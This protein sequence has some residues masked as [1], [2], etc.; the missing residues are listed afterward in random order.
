M[1]VSSTYFV[2]TQLKALFP[3]AR[4]GAFDLLFSYTIESFLHQLD[5]LA[6]IDISCASNTSGYSGRRLSR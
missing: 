1:T 5:D 2:A 3:R 6:P 4:D